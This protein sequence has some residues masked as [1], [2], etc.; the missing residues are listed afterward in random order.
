MG[1]RSRQRFSTESHQAKDQKGE[2]RLVE[3]TFLIQ[4]INRDGTTIRGDKDAEVESAKETT[5]PLGCC[6]STIKP[7]VN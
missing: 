1:L 7:L 2:V 6:E 5:T 3:A 4:M